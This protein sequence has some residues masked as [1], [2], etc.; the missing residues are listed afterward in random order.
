[1]TPERDALLCARYPHLYRDRLGDKRETPMAYGIQC[2]DGWFDLLDRLSAKLEP[3]CLDGKLKAAQVKSKFGALRFYFAWMDDHGGPSS[4]AYAAVREA[5]E[6][7][8]RTCEDCG[9]PGEMRRRSV[10]CERCWAV[11]RM[12][13]SISGGVR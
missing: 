4:E 3:M 2:G 12:Q 1:M 11:G 13:G 8:A 7:A 5:E 6:E 10:Q 9:R